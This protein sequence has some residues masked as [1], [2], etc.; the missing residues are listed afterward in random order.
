M[1]SDVTAPPR[2]ARIL[3]VDDHDGS[4][5]GTVRVLKAAGFDVIEATMGGEAIAMADATI[6]LMVLDVNLPDIDGF[7]VCRELRSRP[8]TADLPV[9]YLSATF[10]NNAD[11][12]L[13]MRVG[14]DSYL[15]HP[16]DPVALVATVRA[17]LFV[18][19]AQA[20]RRAANAR[21]KRLFDL[22]P[23]GMVMLDAE[24]RVVDANPAF[25]RLVARP[26]DAL[27][28]SVVTAMLDEPG[29]R[30]LARASRETT[31]ESSWQGVLQLCGARDSTLELEWTLTRD[32]DGGLLIAMVADVT[33]RRLTETRQLRSLDS[34]RAARAEAE[35][36]NQLKDQFL[37]TLSHELR[38]PLGAILGWASV[39]KHSADLPASLTK[40]LDAIER[41]A[42]VQSHLISDLLDFAGI[43][44]GKM[45][46]EQQLVDASRIVRSAVDTVSHQ[47][48]AKKIDLALVAPPTVH[49]VWGDEAR[50]QQ[51]VWNLLTN[52]IKFTPSG[53]RVTVEARTL[54]AAFEICVTDTGRGISAEFLPRLFDRFSQ[55]DASRTKSFGGL[56]IGL[57]IVR[58]LIELHEGTI[59]A[60]SDGEGRGATFIVRLPLATPEAGITPERTAG[61]LQGVRVL[62]VEDGED[63]RELI[64]R[65]LSDAGAVVSEAQN[66]QQALDSVERHPPEVLV[67]DIGMAKTDGYMLLRT[68]RDG[69]WP[70][71]RLPAIALTAFVRSQ[72]QAEALEAGFQVHL[73]K[74]VNANALIGAVARLMAGRGA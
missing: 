17:L 71:S 69:G 19:E 16:A 62:V 57:T 35:L 15:T 51:I 11:R 4:R 45:R 10:T 73:G 26:R 65:L 6:E 18:R 54:D 46:L 52:A 40:A 24:L 30:T 39:L 72:D 31:L 21:F 33:E 61:A 56:G 49:L 14:A 48:N 41:N 37:A 28:D 29:A 23:L 43:R 7:Q 32:P 25:S 2:G 47:A 53:G 74:P 13:G 66:A 5:Y 12:D 8:Q 20:S 27:I 70:A 67:S 38:N 44:F 60:S 50:L 1:E 58:H 9:V 64:V 63:T 55:Q 34:E 59:G 68:L 3:V 36:S 42:K 22:A